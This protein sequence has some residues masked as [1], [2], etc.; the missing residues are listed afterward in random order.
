MAEFEFENNMLD[1][2]VHLDG[3]LEMFPQKS[4]RGLV[5]RV[6]LASLVMSRL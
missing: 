3:C 2:E 4:S 6:G 5:V 1:H